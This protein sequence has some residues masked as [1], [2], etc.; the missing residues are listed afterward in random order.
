[1]PEATLKTRV[2]RNIKI[3][4][5][6][7]TEEIEDAAS[8]KDI[9][10]DF[11]S[12]DKFRE[13]LARG[14]GERAGVF[15]SH[16]LAMATEEIE[17]LIRLRDTP[18]VLVGQGQSRE[19]KVLASALNQRNLYFLPRRPSLEQVR[20]AVALVYAWLHEEP[21]TRKEAPRE[22][23]HILSNLPDTR[24]LFDP[25]NGRLDARKIAKL[26]GLPLRSLA[27][28]LGIEYGTVHKT[29]SSAVVHEALLDYERVARA[30]SLLSGDRAAFKQWLNR[31]NRDL[32][33]RTPL[34]AIKQGYLASVADLVESAL[35]G[36]PR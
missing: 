27:R 13:Y 36:E 34:D 5:F 35:L 4:I 6:G 2:P 24:F 21:S 12:F 19:A 14:H 25:A 20:R 33:Q 17:E 31:K 16:D 7:P 18:S 30:L 10:W 28:I 26:F 23:R 11:A 8:A 29:S 22:A 32:G 9:R 15:I 3:A 1:M